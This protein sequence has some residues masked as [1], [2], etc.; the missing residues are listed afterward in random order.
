MLGRQIAPGLMRHFAAETWEEIPAS[1]WQEERRK[2]YQAIRYD[3]NLLIRA[4]DRDAAAIRVARENAATA[5]VD[6]CIQFDCCDAAG[7][8]ADRPSS[9]VITNPPYGKRIGEQR[10]IQTLYRQFY[11]FFHEHPT[12]SLF[13]LTADRGVEEKCFGRKADRRR[14]LYNGNIEVCYYQFHGEKR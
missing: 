3:V 5:G 12:W 7:M 4:S 11:R 13:L 10:D 8:Q 2:A 14:K 9:I 1:L 6:D